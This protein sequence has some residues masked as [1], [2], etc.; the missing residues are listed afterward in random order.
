MLPSGS[1]CHTDSETVETKCLPLGKIVQELI[2]I[3]QQ[4][5]I[6]ALN[7]TQTILALFK[8]PILKKEGNLFI[9]LKYFFLNICIVHC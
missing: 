2:L 8:V 5:C 1:T 4:K 7:A 9:F 6:D 3:A